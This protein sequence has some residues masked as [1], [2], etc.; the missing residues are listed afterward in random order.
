[1]H[2]LLLSLCLLSQAP[3]EPDDRLQFFHAKL[4]EYSLF[5]QKKP[6]APLTLRKESIIFYSN[7]E[8]PS[9]SGAT[10]L[11]L[12]GARPVAAIS[13]SIRR[14]NDLVAHEM[15]SFSAAPLDCQRR[16]KSIWQPKSGGLL[17]QPF[18]D[19]PPPADGKRQRLTQMR[20]LA[21][22]FTATRQ[23]STDTHPQELRLLTTPLYRFTAADQGIQDG[24]VFAFA[25]SNDPDL[26]LLLEATL[27]PPRWQYSLAR[28]AAVPEVVRLDD[29]EIWSVANYH[30]Q[31][32]DD[33]KS[34][35]Y[36]EA[37]IG[38]FTPAKSP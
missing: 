23:G 30:R 38:T 24:A 25:I 33:K 26:L 11:W 17:T 13:L 1:M 9:H 29:A 14:P 4:A 16:G 2:S 7:P 31:P 35:P 6:D 37:G 8:G 27:Q 18:A 22:R 5:R 34:G 21:R 10:F 12:D 28:M 20:N 15:T 3:S 19:A 32:P 36:L